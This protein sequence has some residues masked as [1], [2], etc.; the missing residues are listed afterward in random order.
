MDIKKG[1]LIV[2]TTGD[3]SDYGIRDHM[4]AERDFNPYVEAQRFMDT[5]DYLQPPE[6]DPTGDPDIYGSDDRFLAWCIREG[7][8]SPVAAEEVTELHIGSYGRLEL[9]P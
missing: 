4:R 7:F 9:S 8:L 1:Q 2:I 6:Y 5:G 3:Y